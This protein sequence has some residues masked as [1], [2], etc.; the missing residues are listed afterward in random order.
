[1]EMMLGTIIFYQEENTGDV[2]KEKKGRAVN[3]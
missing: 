1:M 2:G 3:D